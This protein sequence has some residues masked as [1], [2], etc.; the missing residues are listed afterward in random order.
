MRG[1]EKRKEAVGHGRKKESRLRANLTTST[2][3]LWS[4]KVG[5]EKKILFFFHIPCLGF[6][7]AMGRPISAPLFPMNHGRL[8]PSAPEYTIIHL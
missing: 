6:N 7:H 1:Q 8:F 2:K 3:A 5:E 4:T